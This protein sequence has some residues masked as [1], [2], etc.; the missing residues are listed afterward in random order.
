M[1][2]RPET[3]ADKCNLP[4]G[5]CLKCDGKL[6]CSYCTR[7]RRAHSCHF[8]PSAATRRRL[9]APTRPDPS[10][11]SSSSR[12]G[13]AT[14]RRTPG[15]VLGGGTAAQ[16]NGSDA[17]ADEEAIVPREARLVCDE[18]GKLIFIGDCA[19]LSLFQT[20][21]QIVTMRVDARAFAPESSRV[22][23]LENVGADQAAPCASGEPPV[24]AGDVGRLVE[25]YISVT[26]ALVDLF[27]NARLAADIS[28][29]CAQ[30]QRPPDVTSA[31]HYLVLAIGSQSADEEAAARYFLQ[32]KGLALSSLGGNLSIGTVQ[33]FV[34]VTLYMVR[35][36]QINGAFLFFGIAVRAAYSIGIHR[37]ELNSRFGADVHYRRDRLWKSLRVLDL[38]LSISMGRPPATSD[39]DCTVPYQSKGDDGKENFDLLNASVQVLL[40][41][42]GIVLEVYHRRKITLQLTEGISLQLREWSGRW[43]APLLRSI[44][45]TAAGHD[46]EVIGGCQALSSYYYAVMLVSR[47]F[48]IYELCKRLPESTTGAQQPSGD[49]NSG[50]SK[51]A[52]ACIDAAC[53]MIEMVL[54][55]VERGVLDQRMPLIVS[56]LFAASL[57]VG[58]G[59]LGG[60]GRVLEKYARMSIAALDHFAVRLRDAHAMQYALIARN[61]LSVALEYLDRKET[62]ERLRTTEN[63]SLLFGLLVPP[64]AAE[65]QQQQQQHQQQVSTAASC[66]DNNRDDGGS[67]LPEG[68]R[69]LVTSPQGGGGD[70]GGVLPNETSAHQWAAAASSS[71]SSLL[72]DIDPGIFSLGGSII[73]PP[74]PAYPFENQHN[75]T[76]QVFGALNLFP[77]LEGNGHI[78]LAHYL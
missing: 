19:P 58:V 75:Q 68:P 4:R 10:S 22:S 13:T 2:R 55:L 54:D 36:C 14:P 28:S 12:R 6:P 43:L 1:Q 76:D 34:L 41:A 69:P 72:G 25:V 71:S 26:S 32:A 63:S 39:S 56:W 77:L 53:L 61:L 16:R 51:L 20:V 78:D 9:T 18:Q 27:D 11:S 62:E 35:S 49:T 57:V 24:D 21:R 59:L 50:R 37:T 65:Q 67:S 3:A 60:F 38:F 52:N 31:V 33:A 40:I 23:M 8:S 73:S 7:R 70:G 64:Q 30:A 42:E 47:P 74:P 15:P 48:L 5:I 45:E 17:S 29:W 46:S 66:D 44:S